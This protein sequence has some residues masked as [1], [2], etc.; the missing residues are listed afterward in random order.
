MAKS[1]ENPIP[2]IPSNSLSSSSSSSIGTFQH[3]GDSTP[4]C[5]VPRCSLRLDM[6][7][8]TSVLAILLVTKDQYQDTKCSGNPLFLIESNALSVLRLLKAPAISI[9]TPRVN[10]FLRGP[11]SASST[12]C[13]RAV[14][15][16]YTLE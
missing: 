7:P 10:S 15:T 16:L 5:G 1:Y 3:R 12:T 2:V 14:S 6:V 8:R 4:P 9:K 13:A 11:F